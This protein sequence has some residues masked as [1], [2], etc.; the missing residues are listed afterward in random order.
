MKFFNAALLSVAFGLFGV[1]AFFFPTY[2]GTVATI[3]KILRS[4]FG[5]FCVVFWAF[6]CAGFTKTKK[7]ALDLTFILLSTAFAIT[8]IAFLILTFI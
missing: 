3:V 5:V 8:N 7:T 6:A 4:F 2:A 1:F